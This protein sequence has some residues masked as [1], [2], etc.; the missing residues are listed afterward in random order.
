MLYLL[1]E[2]VV[3]V[4]LKLRGCP[5]TVKIEVE[6]RNVSVY[7]NDGMHLAADVYELGD[8]VS[9]IERDLRRLS[10]CRDTRIGTKS[11]RRWFYIHVTVTNCGVDV[12]APVFF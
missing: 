11:L 5:D 3:K 9:D 1:I 2:K 10:I 12:V 8:G 4:M 7:G 6:G